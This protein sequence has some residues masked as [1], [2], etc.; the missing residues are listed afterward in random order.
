MPEHGSSLKNGNGNGCTMY[1]E[2]EGKAAG[3]EILSSTAECFDAQA[4]APK[5]MLRME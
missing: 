5:L 3:T 4:V 2:N 1:F